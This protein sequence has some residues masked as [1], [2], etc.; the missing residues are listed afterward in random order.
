MLCINTDK[1]IMIYGFDSIQRL[2]LEPRFRKVMSNRNVQYISAPFEFGKLWEKITEKKFENPALKLVADIEYEK[3]LIGIIRHDYH[4]PSLREEV[5]SRARN[6]F[7]A[8]P[9]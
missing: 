5:I 6:E 1:K 3:S 7:L 2:W 9:S 4:H 8:C